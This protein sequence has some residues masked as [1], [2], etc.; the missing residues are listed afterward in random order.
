MDQMSLTQF[1]Q[2]LI[3]ALGQT[4]LSSDAFVAILLDDERWLIDLMQLKEASVPPK[5]AKN[6]GAPNWVVGI[7]NFKG[8]VWTVIDMRVLVKKETTL[9][10]KWGW[11]TLLRPPE[12][13]EELRLALLWSEIVE[14]APKEEYSF[15]S[16]V[17]LDQFCKAVWLDKKGRDWK[18]LDVAQIG[19]SDGLIQVWRRRT[20]LT[21][22]A[23]EKSA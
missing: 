13:G 18:E 2:K 8:E 5:I 4:K 16:H 11:V 9:N 22:S 12:G 17:Q 14:I 20:E 15:Q 1:Q 7:A 10:P 19:G 3:D 6:T 21:P 23:F